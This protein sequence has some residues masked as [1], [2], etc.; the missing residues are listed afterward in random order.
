MPL[1]ALTSVRNGG[2]SV[3]KCYLE[4]FGDAAFVSRRLADLGWREA[5]QQDRN[6]L[7]PLR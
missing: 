4:P 6:G 7:T 3:T 2:G 1:S 5:R